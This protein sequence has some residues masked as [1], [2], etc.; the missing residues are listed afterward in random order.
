MPSHCKEETNLYYG[1]KKMHLSLSK[2]CVRSF[3][4]PQASL[5]R[6]AWKRCKAKSSKVLLLAGRNKDF[7]NNTVLWSNQS[8]IQDG[9]IPIMHLMLTP[10][11]NICDESKVGGW[12]PCSFSSGNVLSTFQEAKDHDLQLKAEIKL[13]PLTEERVSQMSKDWLPTASSLLHE[14]NFR[15]L[16]SF[17]RHPPMPIAMEAIMTNTQIGTSVDQLR[18]LTHSHDGIDWNAGP[19]QWLCQGSLDDKKKNYTNLSIA[20]KSWLLLKASYQIQ[21][22]DKFLMGKILHYFNIF[23]RLGIPSGLL[24]QETDWRLSYQLIVGDWLMLVMTTDC[25]ID[26]SNIISQ[27]AG[28]DWVTLIWSA[29]ITIMFIMSQH[30]ARQIAVTDISE[31]TG[32]QYKECE[33]CQS[34]V[35]LIPSPLSLGPVLRSVHERWHTRAAEWQKL[36]IYCFTLATGTTGTGSYRPF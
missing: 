10:C 28:W 26:R 14:E 17:P 24:R 12:F 11:F 34:H 15:S 19:D 1:E 4:P 5:K 9:I 20:P 25:G 36:S 18:L 13:P 35:A 6:K 27:R 2:S 3:L 31:A 7:C 29:K 30:I 16:K 32:P 22:G 23:D 21:G 8:N 33:W